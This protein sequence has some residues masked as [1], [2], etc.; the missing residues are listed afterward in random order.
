M[1]QNE[2]EL[3]KSQ[4]WFRDHLHSYLGYGGAAFTVIVGW[5]ISHDSV[6]SLARDT[7]D[8]REAAII[9]AV[10]IPVLWVVWYAVILRLHSR[11]PSHPTVIA[12]GYLH[13]YSI[14]VAIAL[15]A[16]WCL[17]ADVI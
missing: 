13:L 12:K 3:T 9:L 17:V 1:N 6:I 8:K 7:D 14:S 2:Q 11:C 5:L 15:F 10:L 4:E 16:L